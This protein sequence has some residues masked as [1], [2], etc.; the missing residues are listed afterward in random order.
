MRLVRFIPVLLFVFVQ[1]LHGQTDSVGPGGAIKFDGLDDYI[2][3]GDVYSDLQLPF[4]ISGWVYLDPS[5]NSP[6]PIF[7]NRNCDPIYTGF[8]LIVNNNVISM[9]YGDGFGGNSPAFRRG[10]NANVNLLNGNWNH[11]TA[12]VKGVS[13]MELY[14]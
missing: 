11:I 4:T 3:F 13:D 7:S 6:A 2:N 8:R 9:D 12:V 1:S 10:K 5:N 14:L